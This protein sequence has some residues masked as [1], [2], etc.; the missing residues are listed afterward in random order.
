METMIKCLRLPLEQKVLLLTAFVLIASIRMGLKCI[1]FHTLL[2]LLDYIQRD[3]SR[4]DC[5]HSAAFPIDSIAWAVT[6]VSRFI[7]HAS[8]LTQALAARA[9]LQRKGISSRLHLG[10][11][12][13]ETG[14]LEAHAWLECRGRIITGGSQDLERYALLVPDGRNISSSNFF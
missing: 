1:R 13:T 5:S 10:V 3:S 14:K 7:P 6:A 12:K 4:Q 9:M 11:A 2:K 8:C